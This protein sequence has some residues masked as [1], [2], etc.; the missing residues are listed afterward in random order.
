MDF[1]LKRKRSSQEMHVFVSIDETVSGRNNILVCGYPKAGKLLL[2]RMKATSDQSANTS[3]R[4][5]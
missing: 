3:T 2:F 4:C 1:V 5:D